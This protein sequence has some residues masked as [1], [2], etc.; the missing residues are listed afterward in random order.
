MNLATGECHAILTYT[1]LYSFEHRSDMQ[2][3]EHKVN[4]LMIAPDGRRF[5]LLHR[6]RKG[7]RETTR[8]VTA[9]CDGSGLYNLLDDGFVS[10][11]TWKNNTEILTFANKNREARGYYL[12]G[13][14][15]SKCTRIARERINNGHPS[16]AADGR[17]LTD[18]Y[19]DR[20][21]IAGIY[22]LDE[23]TG[24]SITLA[25]VFSP[26][27]YDHEVRC[28]LHPRWKRDGS[29]V[30][31]DAAFEGSRQLYTVPAEGMKTRKRVLV[32]LRSCRNKGPVQQTYNIL[33]HLEDPALEPVFF[34]VRKEDPDDTLMPQFELLPLRRDA[35]DGTAKGVLLGILLGRGRIIRVMKSLAPD[36][37]HTSGIVMDLLGYRLA[38]QIKCKLVLTV[39]NYVF[40]D[41][42]PKFGRMLGTALACLHLALMRDK[43]HV[44]QVVCCSKSLSQIYKQRH[45]VT[46]K[47]I[48][49]GVDTA[50]FSRIKLP[51]QNELREKL[52]IPPQKRVFITT[53]QII[54]RKNIG[55]TV[56]A[57]QSKV[58]AEDLL[59]IVGGGAELES[60]QGR[61]KEQRNVRF[62]G[63]QQNVE[64]WLGASDVFV[65]SSQ[66][67]GLPNSVI[68]AM[69]MGLPVILSD[70]PQHR[71]L[72]EMNAGIG[73]L[74]TLYDEVDLAQKMA[75]VTPVWCAA[76]TPECLRVS[77]NELSAERMSR[78][79][80]RLYQNV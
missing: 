6:W 64:E 27:R 61:F 58:L 31:F 23:T 79:Y 77:H 20:K 5:M 1:D 43:R 10:H 46:P 74:Y 71:E 48:R 53:A 35:I 78:E 24:E 30:C 73:A 50:R 40:D 54:K 13:D 28:D 17:I 68:E 45:G 15:S 44:S 14:Q 42:P 55:E 80:Q 19:P 11:C 59:M 26:F 16:Y 4:H 37:V 69:A 38:R 67:E 66:S 18:S 3:A 47:A 39:R 21:R 36:V 52:G 63:K 32:C 60:L 22:V 75:E 34:T 2:G 62:T 41:Y 7:G 9:Y 33:S 65:S 49:N 12:L 25:K 76:C 29:E 57:F 51:N 70:I 56:R 72:F 8:L